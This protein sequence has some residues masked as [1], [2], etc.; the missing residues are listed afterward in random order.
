MAELLSPRVRTEP[1]GCKPI[2]KRGGGVRHLA[3][4]S[5][6]DAAAWDRIGGALA[7]AVERILRPEIRANRARARSPSGW[8]LE[9]HEPALDAARRAA[10]RLMRHAGVVVRTDVRSFYA[11][12]TPETLWRS[13]ARTGAPGAARRAAGMLEDWGSGG[14]SGL[15]IGPRTSALLANAVLADADLALG[16]LPFLRWV[17]DYLIAVP[18]ERAAILALSRLDDALGRLELSR[19]PEKTLVEEGG[20]LRTWLG[21]SAPA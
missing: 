12:V 17:D 8:R 20:R 9:R 2:A 3:V 11:S 18:D 21:V 7:G 19:A 14:H 10:A 4:L 5:P 15:P 6:R 1:V 16:T 13:L